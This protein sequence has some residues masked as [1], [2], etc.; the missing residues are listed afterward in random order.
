ME[1]TTKCYLQKRPYRKKKFGSA[2]NKFLLSLM[3]KKFFAG[4]DSYWEHFGYEIGGPVCYG[5]VKWII[6]EVEKNHPDITDLAFVARDGWVL[7]KV[8]DLLPHRTDL[9]SHY[10][11]A[12]RTMNLLCQDK[13]KHAEYKKYLAEKEFGNGTLAVVDTVTMK[14]SSQ[15]LIASAVEQNTHGFFWVV[16]NSLKDYGASFNFS[17]Y[18]A[19]HY[20]TIRCWNLME[21]IMTSPEPPIRSMEGSE[22]IYRR[23]NV[24]EVQRG[25]IFEQIEAGVLEF[26]RDVCAKGKFPELNN[27]FVT[28]WVNKF[29]KHPAQ[30]DIDAFENVM[31]SELEDHSDSIPLN[32]FGQQAISLKA[33]KDRLWLF[34]QRHKYL[35]RV[36]RA[37]NSARKKVKMLLKG[38]HCARFNG[39]DPQK[40]AEV[41][42]QYDVVS[43]DVFDTLIFREVDKPTDLFYKLEAENKLFDFH[44][45][46]ISAEADARRNLGIPN[47]EVNIFD[48]YRELSKDYMLDTEKEV[49]EELAAEKAVCYANP[50]MKELY[51]MLVSKG[52][53]IIVVSDMYI[54][55]KYLR[56]LLED[57]GYS[58]IERVF[59]SCDHGV[60]KGNGALQK[61]VQ[62]ELG[63]DL[64]F[65]HVGDNQTS[66]VQ[67]SK[68]AGWSAVW[69]QKKR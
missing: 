11:Y 2:E 69:Y 51:Q 61:L 31:F 24:F 29:L 30:E 27:V 44:D 60:G 55:E 3:G 12:P 34:S 66:D 25:A 35:Y 39:S 10:I 45:N 19:A 57:C 46:R 36:L 37:G 21:F 4:M 52:C 15:R 20:H 26:V 18:Q 64:R 43:F 50:A 28:E 7:Q 40:L 8:F 62:S 5:Y 22:P 41:L 42:M 14:F 32:P 16:L 65:I 63:D 38:D 53:R 48:I 49:S 58:N 59:V 54:P 33:L 13:A 56:E 47:G 68:T 1:H 9:R 67:G 17:T 23:A 6:D